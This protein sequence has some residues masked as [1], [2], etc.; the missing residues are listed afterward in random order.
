[1]IDPPDSG[2]AFIKPG[3]YHHHRAI[4]RMG[5]RAVCLVCRGSWSL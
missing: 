3:V 1:M 4:A 2:R 5:N